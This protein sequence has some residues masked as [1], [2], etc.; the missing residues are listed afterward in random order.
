MRSALILI[1]SLIG[2][3]PAA[4]GTAAPATATATCT[5]SVGP[6]IPPPARVPGGIPGF[7]AAWYGQSGY[8]RLCPG[9]RSTA[10]VAYYNSGSRGWVSGRMG[11]VAY[12]GS[13]DSE[14]GQ[15]QPSVLGGDGQLG[16]PNT[17]WPRFNRAALQPAPY[18]GPGQVA[19][20]Q[21]SVQAPARP[22]TYRLGIRPLVEGAQWMEDYGVYW[23]ITVLNP[24]GTTPLATPPSPAGFY[25]ATG[26]GVGA[27]DIADV[28]E[29]VEWISSYLAANAGGDRRRIATA[30]I[31]TGDGTE[32]YCCITQGP[33]FD[34][35]TS[36]RA[37][38]SPPAAAADT[39]T[40][41][42]ERIELAAH[43]YVHVWQYDTGG[44]ACM[45]GGPR[46]IS[47]GMAES[48]AYRSLVAAGRI[49]AA[50]MDTFTKRQLR[51]AQYVTLRSLESTW[52]SAANPFAVAYLAVD[53]LLA[54]PSPL[55]LRTYCARVGAGELWQTAFAAAFGTDADTFYTRFEAYRT[56]YLATP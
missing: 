48:L 42:T 56:Q 35:V 10:T 21:F 54:Q 39:W 45:V 22:G 36:N 25:Y 31:A 49:P 24:D 16:S 38:S 19:W 8:M 6:G 12:L 18:V 47:E 55:A 34:I 26:A 37:W 15:D 43:E 33:T 41:D 17:A 53:R 1:L 40:P 32:Q 13:W 29:G 14:P 3:A 9:E 50:N 44:R 28:H 2:I 5:S 52:P 27:M 51:S 30:R 7:H 46:W 23:E 4:P 20:F 11:E